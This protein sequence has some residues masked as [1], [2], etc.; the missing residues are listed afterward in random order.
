[1]L[2]IMAGLDQKDSL[3]LFG[4][5]MCKAG[6]AGYDAPCAAF[7]FLVVRPKMLGIMAGLDQNDSCVVLEI[8]LFL[9]NTAWSS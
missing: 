6:I 4:S 2:G 8:S 7:S 9:L 1:M 5:G 3:L